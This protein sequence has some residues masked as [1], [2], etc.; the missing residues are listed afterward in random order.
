MES[1]PMPFPVFFFDG[2]QEQDKGFVDIHSVPD[3]LKEV[4]LKEG[5]M[6]KE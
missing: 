5:I 6:W 3:S 1:F 4:I 2:E